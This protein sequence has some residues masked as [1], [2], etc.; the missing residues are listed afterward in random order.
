MVAVV[1]PA[2][3]ALVSLPQAGIEITVPAFARLKIF[4]LRLKLIDP[5]SLPVPVSPNP[6]REGVWLAS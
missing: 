1:Q 5:A 4:Q 3:A 2:T 6:P